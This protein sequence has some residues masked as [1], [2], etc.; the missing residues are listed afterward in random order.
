MRR[1]HTDHARA[2]LA[3]FTDAPNPLL[4]RSDRVQSR[5]RSV[6]ATLAILMIPVSAWLAMAT[7]G[8]QS[9]QVSAQ[10]H[11]RHAVTATT[12]SVN[13]PAPLTQS[14]FSAG[15]STTVDATWTYRGQ[16]HTG[17]VPVVGGSPVGTE[18]D[19]WVDNSGVRA[20]QPLTNTDAIAA[21]L[22]TGIG[23]AVLVSIILYGAYAATRFHL[24][25]RREA[26]W[27]LAIKN[28]MDENSLS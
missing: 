26:D 15:S 23:S 7:F 28:F 8:A 14:E 16:E 20:S 21:A 10:Q 9:A 12:T 3:G 4:R 19:I 22:F 27:D 11:S 2:A 25:A 18:V 5:V 6:V 17:Q 24:N 13:D 1:K